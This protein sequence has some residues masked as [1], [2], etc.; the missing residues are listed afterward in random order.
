MYDTYLFDL[1]GTLLDI[2]TE[3][4]DISTWRSFCSFMKEYGIKYHAFV[5]RMLFNRRCRALARTESVYQ[6]PEH[7]ILP[8]FE[9]LIRRKKRDK[10]D[11]FIWRCAEAF[12]RLS[13]RR[14]CL[15]KNSI[16]TLDT[17]RAAGK[18]VIL[19]SNAQLV[20][21]KQ[22]IGQFQLEEHFDDIFIS[23]VEGCMK[24]DPAFFM[25]P[26]RKYDLD[27]S[28][29]LM[30]GN[31]ERSDVAGA[32][33]IGMDCAFVRSG[34]EERPLPDCRYVYPDGDVIHVLE[35]LEM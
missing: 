5:A 9:Y 29:C 35:T 6:Y 11:A 31:D 3:E 20:Y 15:Y 25:A 30:I 8:A 13:V 12:R 4:Q 19:L 7:D 2:H 24:P 28:R 16:R 10:D 26:V 22:E 1:Y 23:S 18:K 21:T 17:L 14:I 27:I 34:S 33:R 32:K